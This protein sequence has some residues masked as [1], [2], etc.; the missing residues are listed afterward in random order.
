MSLSPERV[1]VY[2]CATDSDKGENEMS[3]IDSSKFQV[4]FSGGP[5]TANCTPRPIRF[6]VNGSI[7]ILEPCGATLNARSDESPAS[8]P[9]SGVEFVRTI[10]LPSREGDE[11]LDGISERV[12]VIG[13]IIAAQAWPG[14]VVALV[15]V[16]GTERAKPEEKLFEPAKFI[17]F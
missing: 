1:T 5:R 10:Y 6:S 3:S 11:E 2:D 15:P 8:G 13:S 9:V 4:L 7:V 17:V 14:R 16:R 12:L